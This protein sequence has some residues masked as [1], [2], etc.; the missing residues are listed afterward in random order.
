MD[1][2]VISFVVR[3]FVRAEYLEGAAF[4]RRALKRRT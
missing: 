4:E 1:V 2:F 3:S